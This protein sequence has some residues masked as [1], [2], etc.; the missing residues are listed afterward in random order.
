MGWPL[1]VHFSC[2][3]TK[4]W[5]LPM[6]KRNEICRT[7]IPTQNRWQLILVQLLDDSSSSACFCCSCQRSFHSSPI[8]RSRM[9]FVVF[10][11]HNSLCTFASRRQKSQFVNSLLLHVVA[12]WSETLVMMVVPRK[13]AHFKLTGRRCKRGF[14]LCRCGTRE[15]SVRTYCTYVCGTRWEAAPAG[16]E[17]GVSGGT[18]EAVSTPVCRAFYSTY[19]THII[20]YTFYRRSC[21]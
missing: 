1:Y 6:N 10:P 8:V 12:E 11:S 21:T 15:A 19:S 2:W 18:R 16:P 14:E 13:A 7:K 17:K 20:A 9:S 4:D 5:Q 3:M